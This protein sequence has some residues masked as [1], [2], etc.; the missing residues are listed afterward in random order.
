MNFAFTI[1]EDSQAWS[2]SENHVFAILKITE[3]YD[4]ILAGLQDVCDEAQDIEAIS[5]D[6]KFF[7]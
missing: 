5:I 3:S 4:E 7:M 2:A 1:L 6:E